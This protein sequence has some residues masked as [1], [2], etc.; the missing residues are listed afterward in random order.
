MF[1][2]KRY[3]NQKFIGLM[4]IVIGSIG[5]MYLELMSEFYFTILTLISYGVFA[6]L[7]SFSFNRDG[8]NMNK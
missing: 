6:G 4:T 3:F 1:D 8:I 2:S 5:L 7:E